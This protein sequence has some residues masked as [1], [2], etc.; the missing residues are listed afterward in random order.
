MS[1]TSRCYSLPPARPF[2][3]NNATRSLA[4]AANV[5]AIA[6]V[7]DVELRGKTDANERYR[8]AMVVYV[9]SCFAFANVEIRCDLL[10]ANVE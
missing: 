1:R 3:A 9:R 7:S 4:P 10:H 8:T 5:R 2:R 6:G